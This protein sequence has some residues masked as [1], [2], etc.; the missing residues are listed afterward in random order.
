MSLTVISLLLLSLISYAGKKID[1]TDLQTSCPNG[2]SVLMSGKKIFCEQKDP[3]IADVYY[4][5]AK[6][7]SGCSS[8]YESS[9]YGN[10]N[11]CIKRAH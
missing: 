11:W 3:K 1:I 8:G 2:F 9:V 6:D 4:K 10:I 7:R 5:S